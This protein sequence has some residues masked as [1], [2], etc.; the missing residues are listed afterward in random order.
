M[1]ER[2]MPQ[3]INLFNPAFQPQKKVVTATMMGVSLLVLVIGIAALGVSLR[4]ATARM[5]RE[6]DTEAAHLARKQARLAT[7]NAEF[8][9]RTKNP[10]LEAQIGEAE[11]QLA[12]LRHVSGVLQRG[13]LGDTNGYAG[14][15][16]ALARQGVQGLWLTGVSVAGPNIGI[17]GRTTDPALVPGYINR[18]TQEPLLQGKSFAS[19][20]IG[21]AAPV[22]AP[23]PDGKP[24]Q[25]AA[26]YVEFSLQSVVEAPR[27]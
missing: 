21:Q 22:Q 13:E 14:Y 10:E 9:P 5:E 3:Q 6:R 18:L 15:F 27:P 25:S 19:L 4:A 17:K 24:V 12:A 1:T 2:T 8:A 7:V 26:P 23:G 11:A 16:K 20:Q